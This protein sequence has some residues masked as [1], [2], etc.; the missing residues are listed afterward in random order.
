MKKR[1]AAFCEEYLIDLSPKN[2]A[3]RAGFAPSTA[4]DA[5]KWLDE[6]NDRLKPAVRARIDELLAER[7]RRTGISADRVI[8]ELARLAFANPGDVI[9][10]RNG[11]VQVGADD[12]DMAAIAAVRVKKGADFEEREVRMC[13]KA[14]ALEL[15]GKHLGIF[16]DRVRL[17]GAVPVIID[18]S[19][20]GDA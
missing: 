12:D 11:G 20:G 16:A 1:D 19:G 17:E 9:D 2:A 14:R 6:N 8:R 10:M 3:I 5:W 13:D 4:R 15:L 7:S 18:D